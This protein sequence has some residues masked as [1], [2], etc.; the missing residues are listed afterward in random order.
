MLTVTDMVFRGN[1]ATYTFSDG[2]EVTAIFVVRDGVL[3]Y[4]GLTEAQAEAV[5][6]FMRTSAESANIPSVPDANKYSEEENLTGDLFHDGRPIY[7]KTLVVDSFTVSSQYANVPHGIAEAFDLVTAEG[8]VAGLYDTYAF[9]KDNTNVHWFWTGSG[10]FPAM[11]RIT[12]VKNS[13]VSA[14]GSPS[15]VTTWPS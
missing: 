5:R 9:Y 15:A 12:Y 7:Q 10:S 4:E 1:G 2:A 6:V 14:F 8:F 3:C 13:T 11:V